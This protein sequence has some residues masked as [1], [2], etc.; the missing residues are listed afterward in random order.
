MSRSAR[1]AINTVGT[2]ALT[3]EI[4]SISFAISYLN[5][6]TIHTTSYQHLAV[7]LQN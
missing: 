3:S 5:T 6:S 4:T 2:V 7:V 1:S